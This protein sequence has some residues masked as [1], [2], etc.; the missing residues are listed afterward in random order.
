MTDT[1]LALSLFSALAVLAVGMILAAGLWARARTASQDQ[2]ELVV[3]RSGRD[4]AT[5]QWLTQ[6]GEYR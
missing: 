5:P 2:R 3:E 4:G 6:P 1:G